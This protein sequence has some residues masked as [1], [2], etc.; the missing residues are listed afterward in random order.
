MTSLRT[1]A[2]L[3]LPGGLLVTS[4]CTRNSVPAATPAASHEPTASY[5]PKALIYKTTC[6]CPDLVPVGVAPNGCE[7]ISYPAPSDLTPSSMPLSLTDGW[8]LDRRGITS[9]TRFTTFT[10]TEYRSLD[11]APDPSKLLSSL[12]RD[13]RIIEIRELPM[14][15]SEAASDTAAVNR[16]ITSGLSGCKLIYSLPTMKH[17]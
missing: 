10:Y 16:F 17:P 13:C 1:M 11:K 8:W 15:T 3:S 6:D 4:G 2:I 7:L 5:M 14:T 9:T 12:D